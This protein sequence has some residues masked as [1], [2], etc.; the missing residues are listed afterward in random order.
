MNLSSIIESWY[1]WMRYNRSYSSNTLE[2]YIRDLKDLINFLN[3]HIGEEVN[4]S[5]LKKLSVPELRSWLSS[6]YIRG[7]NARSNIRALSVIRNFFRYIKNNYEISNDAVFSLSKPIQRRTLPKV[8][9]ISDIETLVKKTKLSNLGEPWVI[10]REIAIIV[11]LYGTGLR[12]SEA[13]NLKVGDVRNESLIVTGKG[14]KQ[15]KVFILSVVK[16]Y[17]QEYIKACPYLDINNEAQYLFVGVKGKKLKRTYVAN[18]LQKIRRMLNLPEIVSPHAFRHSFATHLLQ[19]SIDVR[20]I[21][22]LLGHS[23]L[24]TTQVYIHLNYRDIFNMYKNA[25]KNLKKG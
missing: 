23:S 7:I 21:Q 16:K 14:N 15:R 6:R 18:R 24:E 13:L 25:Q 8:L 19:E 2:S 17:I 3:A 1:E 5:S 22:Q 20:S 11:L 9:S 4:V 12:V 10:K